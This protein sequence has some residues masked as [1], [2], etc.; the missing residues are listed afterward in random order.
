MI[1]TNIDLLMR[2]TMERLSPKLDLPSI[3]TP[4]YIEPILFCITSVLRLRK[5][6]YITQAKMRGNDVKPVIK[7]IANMPCMTP[8][9]DAQL[10]S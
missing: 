10:I 8:D 1:A 2:K 3:Q 4:K 7:T 5:L 6:A 9:I